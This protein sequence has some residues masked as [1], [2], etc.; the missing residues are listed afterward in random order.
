M[1]AE[2]VHRALLGKTMPEAHLHKVDL[3]K[4][5]LIPLIQKQEGEQETRFQEKQAGDD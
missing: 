2:Q 1:V 4:A 5:A 3:K